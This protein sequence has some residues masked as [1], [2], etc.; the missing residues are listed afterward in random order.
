MPVENIV[1]P[2]KYKFNPD[3]WFTVEENPSGDK[4]RLMD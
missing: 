2:E 1:C 4:K 3:F